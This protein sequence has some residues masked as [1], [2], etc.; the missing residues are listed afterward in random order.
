MYCNM[1][2]LRLLEFEIVRREIRELEINEFVFVV[3]LQSRAYDAG[4]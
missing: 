3:C 1:L 2:G 4:L